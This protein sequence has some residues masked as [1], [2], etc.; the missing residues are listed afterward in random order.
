M[1]LKLFLF[2]WIILFSGLNLNAVELKLDQEYL[3]ETKQYEEDY[4]F[5]GNDLKFKGKA[6]DLFLLAENI[7]FLGTSTLAVFG[8]GKEI[9]VAGDVGNGVKAAG[10]TI[11]IEGNIKGTSF[12]AGETVN[13]TKESQINGDTFIGARNINLLG[14]YTGNLRAAAAEISVQNEIFGNVIA[15]TGRL[16]IPNQGRIIGNL[17]YHSEKE[18]SAEEASRVTGKVKYELH[19]GQMYKDKLKDESFDGLI[20]FEL[21]FKIAFILFGLLILLFPVNKFLERQYNRNEIQSYALWGL[22]PIFIYPSALVISV[23]LVITMPLAAV[24]FF[25]FMPLVFITKVLGITMIGGYLVKRFNLKTISRFLYFLIGAVLYSLF[26]FIP[27]FG[28]LLL[29][30]VSS[31]GCGLILFNL[32]NKKLT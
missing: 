4:L 7:H 23:V 6:N 19:K 21:F 28:F 12:L 25:A 1:K 27:Y 13:F 22:L 26:S 11:N 17:T 3:V 31:I 30:F 16:T 18:L 8:M 20:W 5:F 10:G 9:Y 2:I 15:H 24:M 14:K 32:F 29:V